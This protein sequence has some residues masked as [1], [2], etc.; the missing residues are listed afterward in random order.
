MRKISAYVILVM[1]LLCS[2]AHADVFYLTAS[3]DVGRISISGADSADLLGTQYTTSWNDPFLG[4]YW[5]GST[6]RVILVDRTT[7][8]AASGDTA[9]IF[10]PSDMTA[11]IESARKVLAG[12][13]SAQVMAGSDNGRAIFFASGNSVHEFSTDD[14]SLTR[15]YTYTPKTSEDITSEIIGMITGSNTINIL[16]QQDISRDVVLRFDGQLKEDV[17]D[18]F[19]RRPLEYETAAISWLSNSRVAAGH[20]YGVDIWSNSRGFL[21]VLSTDAPVKAL[22]EDGGNGF[23]FIEQSESEGRYTTIL[24]HYISGEEITTLFTTTE[25]QTYR[26]IRDGDNGLIAAIVGGELLV[27]WMHDDVLLG[28]YDSYD[29]GGKPVQITAS[30]VS[31]DDGKKSNNCSVSGIGMILIFAV[32]FMFLKEKGISQ[33]ESVL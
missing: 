32:G 19:Q 3:G 31:G 20:E 13:Y 17:K 25:G 12:V 30:N 5:D 15:S 26:L 28:E 9:L 8:T 10:N 23:Y 27:Y 7:N 22:C 29:L 6:T 14:F 2:S 18:S 24:K 21:H 33:N 11:P 4:S 16:L 1:M